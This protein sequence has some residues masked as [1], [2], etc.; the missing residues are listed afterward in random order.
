VRPACRTFSGDKGSE[1]SIQ[2]KHLDE[3]RL[4]KV[5]AGRHAI[6]ALIFVISAT[7]GWAQ[8]TIYADQGK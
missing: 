5:L 2:D 1:S 6:C 8:I 4:M 3:E 7:T